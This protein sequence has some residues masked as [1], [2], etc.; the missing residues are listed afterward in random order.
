MIPL[1]LEPGDP[2]ALG[3]Y[4][5]VGRLGAGGQGVVYLG[6]RGSGPQVAIKLLHARLLADEHARARFVRE[7][8]VL[9]RVAGFCT[10]QMLG[11]DVA[12]D[13]PYIVSEYVPGPS[14][15][16]L[17]TRQGPRTGADL[18]RLAI[19][20]VTAL[21]AIHR[22]GVVHRDFKP[23]NV[24]IGPDGPRVIDFGVARALDTSATLTSQIIGTPAYMAPEQFAGEE[25]GPALDLFAWGATMV[26]AATGREVFAGGPMPAVMYRVL[27]EDPDLSG[28]PPRLRRLVAA[29]LNKDPGA[30]PTA[31]Q[32]LLTLLGTAPPPSPVSTRPDAAPEPELRRA[33][34]DSSTRLET[35]EGPYPASPAEPPMD[36]VEGDLPAFPGAHREPTMPREPDTGSWKT[37]PADRAPNADTPAR[38]PASPADRSPGLPAGDSD[39]SARLRQEPPASAA[40][41]SPGLRDAGLGEDSDTSARLREE[42]PAPDRGRSPDLR[43]AGLGEDSGAPARFREAPA[44][45]ERP[46]GSRQDAPAPVTDRSS[47]LG[48]RPPVPRGEGPSGTRRLTSPLGRPPEA[49]AGGPVDERSSG[50]RSEATPAVGVRS[51]GAVRSSGGHR[52]SRSAHTGGH[53]RRVLLRRTPSLVTGLTLAVLLA[54]LDIAALGLLVASPALS[55][56][57][58]EFVAAAGVFTLL[59]MI[60]IVAAAVAWRGS[61]T[62]TLAVIIVRVS[63]EALWAVWAAVQLQ[64]ELTR[65]VQLQSY[66][67]HI[68]CTVAVAALLLRALRHPAGP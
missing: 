27:H 50:A 16:E 22:A 34:P 42:A 58:A 59:S 5:L 64:S 20:T 53:R 66:V 36:R 15:Q 35:P 49:D 62:A 25:L 65:D 3:G 38:P 41:R 7:L 32:I 26:F 23:H 45:A 40:D 37:V 12:G 46:P 24:L 43:N 63:R 19:G 55:G 29:C 39:A 14:L 17:V 8:A 47:A 9:Q 11:A 61:R 30:R 48:R 68:A 28:L 21:A 54:A 67:F 57:R 13:Q 44:S 2:P 60:T 51:S 10:A 56:G 33:S 1:P 31:E 6:R 52:R 4:E 18:D